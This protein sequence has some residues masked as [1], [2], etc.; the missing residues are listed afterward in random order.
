MS[1]CTFMIDVIISFLL[2]LLDRALPTTGLSAQQS[3]ALGVLVL[4]G[5]ASFFLFGV[6]L[7]PVFGQSKGPE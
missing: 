7:S 3:K 1:F 2:S 6:V 5:D 4:L